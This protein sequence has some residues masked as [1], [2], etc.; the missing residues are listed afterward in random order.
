[1]SNPSSFQQYC[2]IVN[3]HG[4]HTRSAAAIAELAGQFQCAISLSTDKGKSDARDMLRL[5]LLEASMG[6][7]VCISANGENA[8][9]AVFAI[10]ELIKAGF[11]EHEK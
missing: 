6:T 1:M 11:H 4:L 3:K 5:M 8:R 10:M 7:E 2:T 9:E